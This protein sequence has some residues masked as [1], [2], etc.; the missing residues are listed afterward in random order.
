MILEEILRKI[1]NGEINV[2]DKGFISHDWSLKETENIFITDGEDGDYFKLEIWEYSPC[3]D[4]ALKYEGTI[5]AMNHGKIEY[6]LYQWNPYTDEYIL[7]ST[8]EEE[9]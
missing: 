2:Y 9:Y 4:C 5:E 8:N 6:K 7:I 1:K 3:R